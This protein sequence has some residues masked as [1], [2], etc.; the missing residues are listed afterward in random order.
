MTDMSKECARML[1][2]ARYP[3]LE[4]LQDYEVCDR[5]SLPRP[6]RKGY[7]MLDPIFWV[8]WDK[9]AKAAASGG[10]AAGAG[11]GR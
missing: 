4:A 5:R 7:E 9:K 11:G 1:A 2:C 10:A 3:E 8:L 6:L